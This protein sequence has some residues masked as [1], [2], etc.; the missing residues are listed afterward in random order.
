KGATVEETLHR[1]HLALKD[2][3]PEICGWESPLRSR[4]RTSVEMMQP[5]SAWG[6]SAH[7]QVA[8]HLARACGIPAILVKSIKLPTI[9]PNGRANGHVY[10][11]LL[12]ENK[13]V[14]WDA[15]AHK[16]FHEYGR[17]DIIDGNRIYDAGGPDELILSHHGYEWEEE[18]RRLFPR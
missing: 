5:L 13:R 9:Q 11:E 3:Y 14:L 1:I 10:L 18:N 2:T 7:A 17:G 6:C 15:Q 8:C 16:L 4:A 12:I